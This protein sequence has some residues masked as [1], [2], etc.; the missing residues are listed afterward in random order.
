[1]SSQSTTPDLILHNG[2]FTTLDPWNPAGEAVAVKDGK[3]TAVGESK[4]IL[5]LAN[6]DTKI[7]DLQG[8]ARA[9]RPDRQP[10]AHHPRRA[11]LQHGAALGRRALAGR[12]HG[13]LKRQ[14]AITPP[15][16]W[17]RVVGGFTEH[18]FAEKRLPTI[19]EIN[20]VAP[21][22]P[23]FLLHLYDRALLNAAALARRG[24]YQGHAGAAGRRDRPRRKRRSDWAAAG[25]A[26]RR[27]PLCDAGQGAEAALRLPGQLHAPFHARAEPARRHRRHRRRRRLSELSGRLRRH[28]E[29]ADEGQLTIRLAYNLFTQKPKGEKEDFLNWTKTSKYK[30]GNDYFRHNG[31]G[32]MLVFSAADFEDFRQPRP[33]MPPEMEREL[34]DGGAH[35]RSEPLAM[36][37][38]CH[39]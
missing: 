32:E 22:T 37:A 31:G 15:P 6:S 35:S 25:Q 8:P 26:Q 18:Q 2:R 29:A 11:Q 9:A 21:E 23:V 33:D 17:V 34:E 12:C 19:E 4:D 38:A 10:P 20:A 24:L 36:A 30:Q 27:H 7:I 14:I 39:L 3:F 16:Q 1:M 28:R 13:M 5:P